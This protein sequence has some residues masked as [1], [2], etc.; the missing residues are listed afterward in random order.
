MSL[1]GWL[2]SLFDCRPSVLGV[3]PLT[4]NVNKQRLWWGH[5]IRDLYDA[6]HTPVRVTN[7]YQ[8]QMVG[9]HPIWCLAPA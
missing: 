2:A 3:L 1:G 6:G 9:Y 8:F 7:R 5:S 4:K